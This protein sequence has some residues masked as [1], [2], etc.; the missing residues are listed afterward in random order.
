MSTASKGSTTVRWILQ[1]GL[2]LLAA[3]G[4]LTGLLYSGRFLGDRLRDQGT[5]TL[6]FADL[7]CEP[8]PG[9][10]RAEFLRETQYL[11]E[12]PDHFDPLQAETPSLLAA[13][14]IQHPW[15]ARV[16]QVKL[17]PQGRAVVDLVFR[18][19][20]LI[21]KKFARV[22]D[23]H[24]IL[25]PRSARPAGLP[26]LT[27][28][29]QPPTG[30]AGKPW[31]DIRVLAAARTIAFLE[32]RLDSLGLR[33]ATLDTREGDL[34]LETR[35]ARLIWGLPP[36][37]ERDNEASADLK[38]QRLPTTGKLDGQEWDVRPRSGIQKRPFRP[39]K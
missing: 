31:G 6:A 34:V 22:V 12:V 10:S 38:A 23:D 8:P 11:A 13:A 5:T 16:K 4:M 26:V 1:L 24:G 28:D 35:S 27:T 29:V 36:G 18:Q 14:L 9:M 19:P 15:V 30:V 39:S 32:S 2:P 33:N 37:D 20:T 25:L 7:E 3:A 21:V 17:L